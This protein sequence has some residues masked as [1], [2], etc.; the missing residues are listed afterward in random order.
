MAKY[1]AK[2]S[3]KNLSNDE[4]YNAFNSASKHIW[5]MDGLEVEIKTVPDK[6]KEH[7]TEIKNTKKG[8]KE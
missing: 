7:L 3:Y 2:A 8:G 5:L 4:N 1:K 6:L